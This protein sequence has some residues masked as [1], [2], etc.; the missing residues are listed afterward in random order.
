MVFGVLVDVPLLVGTFVLMLVFRKGAVR[1]L[2]RVDIPLFL[3]FLLLSIPLIIFEEDID[4]MPAWC[5]QVI[6]PPTLPF[7]V[8]E[9][10]VLGL[11]AVFLHVRRPFLLVLCYCVFGVGWELTVGGLK[12]A[13]LLV[14]LILV[15]YV[16]LG[17]AYVSML[18]LE[19][20]VGETAYS[21]RKS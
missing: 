19:L 1:A 4:C 5:G 8:F 16:A 12:G 20:L 3:L 7:L 18:P 10:F 14:D 6:I 13:S 11:I 17:Y 15:P 2:A 21:V 9:I